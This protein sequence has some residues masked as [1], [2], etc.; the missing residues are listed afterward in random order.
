[1][2]GIVVFLNKMCSRFARAI[3]RAYH[4]KS[5]PCDITDATKA[6]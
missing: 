6:S 1:L 2:L 4:K 5:Y 3:S